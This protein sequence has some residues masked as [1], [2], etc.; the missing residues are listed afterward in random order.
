MESKII[1]FEPYGPLGAVLDE[2][3]NYFLDSELLQ[4][5]FFFALSRP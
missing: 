2:L 1:K 3:R 5:V 4:Q